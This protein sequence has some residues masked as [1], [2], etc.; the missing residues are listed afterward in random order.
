MFSDYYV[1]FILGE[2]SLEEYAHENSVSDQSAVAASKSK[3]ENAERHL[4]VVLKDSGKVL[5]TDEVYSSL[6]SFSFLA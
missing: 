5:P 1:H 3:L 6:L 2:S 4:K